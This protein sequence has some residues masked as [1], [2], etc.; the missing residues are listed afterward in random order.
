MSAASNSTGIDPT[1]KSHLLLYGA[2]IGDH[3]APLDFAGAAAAIFPN[4]YPASDDAIGLGLQ[5]SAASERDEY[6]WL[7]ESENLQKQFSRRVRDRISDGE[8]THLSVFLAP[9]PLLIRL[10]RSSAILSPLTFTNCIA[11]HR[12][13]LG[14]PKEPLPTT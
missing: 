13:G 5:N 9:Q 4:R 14:L 10:E 2:N 6:F 3:G 7:T 12:L 1:R 11:S 8:I